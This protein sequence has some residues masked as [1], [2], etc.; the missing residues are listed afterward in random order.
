MVGNTEAIVRAFGASESEDEAPT[1]SA[2]AA[3]VAVDASHEPGAAEAA[4]TAGA[5]WRLRKLELPHEIW[6]EL[7]HAIAG[8]PTRV[9]LVL[10]SAGAEIGS[11]RVACGFLNAP[12]D[13]S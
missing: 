2:T 5:P 6:A 10:T 3:M 4:G 13:A 11:I 12:A 8:D 1:V 9:E 7:F